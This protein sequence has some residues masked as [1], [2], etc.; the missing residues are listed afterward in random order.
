MRVLHYYLGSYLKFRH[1]SIGSPRLELVSGPAVS[2]T[3]LTRTLQHS[4][5]PLS[6]ICITPVIRHTSALSL[7]EIRDS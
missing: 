5:T 6:T 7:I 2:I 4:A 3:T 1:S